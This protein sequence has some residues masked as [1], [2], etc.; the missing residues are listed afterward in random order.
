MFLHLGGH[1]DKL[2][3]AVP[4]WSLWGN[5]PSLRWKRWLPRRYTASLTPA[6]LGVLLQFFQREQLIR[7]WP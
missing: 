1:F 3:L 2:S 4:R 5:L 6:M 7:T